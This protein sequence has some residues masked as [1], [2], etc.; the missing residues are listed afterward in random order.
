[1]FYPPQGRLLLHGVLFR[2]CAPNLKAAPAGTMPG[3][4]LTLSPSLLGY[5]DS[6]SRA[7][8]V[9]EVLGSLEGNNAATPCCE[10]QSRAVSAISAISSVSAVSTHVLGPGWSHPSSL[11]AHLQHG[12]AA[13]L[14]ACAISF[15]F[16]CIIFYVLMRVS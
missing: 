7:A 14:P 8:R 10:P 6:S 3:C 13:R 9:A 12:P 4:A 11:P 5:P 1:M 15:P 2:L 16:P